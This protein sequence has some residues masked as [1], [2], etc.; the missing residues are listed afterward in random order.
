MTSHASILIIDDDQWLAQQ[1]RA[2]LE[3]AGYQTHTAS[4]AL[5]GMDMVDKLHPS[6]IILDVFMPGPNGIVLLHELR[7]HSDLAQIPIIVCTNSASD[8]PHG[9]LTKY[10]VRVILDKTTMHPTDVVTAVRRVLL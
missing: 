10:G 7:S 6:A 5:E 8:I 2:L 9:N 4:H 3:K 1:Y